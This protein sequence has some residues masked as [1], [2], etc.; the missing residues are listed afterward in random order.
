MMLFKKD[1]TSCVR[2]RF[3]PFSVDKTN[4]GGK[5]KALYVA[6]ISQY[7]RVAI[8]DKCTVTEVFCI[9]LGVIW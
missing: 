1:I 8:K 2:D 5:Q 7:S 3:C 9:K 4:G 6:R